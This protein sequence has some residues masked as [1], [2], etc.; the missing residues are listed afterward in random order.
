M[1]ST[2][3]TALVT[4][5]L[6]VA[7]LVAACGGGSDTSTAVTKASSAV[8]TTTS[9]QP[10]A[11]STVVPADSAPPKT[12]E[13]AAEPLVWLHENYDG[14]DW[15]PAVKSTEDVFGVLWIETTL[16]DRQTAYAEVICS[17]ASAYQLD[18][19]EFTGVS[20][21]GASGL[22]LAQRLSMG[23]DCAA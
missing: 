8:A 16:H 13:K 14:A 5:G 22:R 12:E 18:Q 1:T 2:R 4:I 11:S 3:A 15:M 20:V 19:G 23:D 21:R 9:S 17:A 7:A 6:V 10:A